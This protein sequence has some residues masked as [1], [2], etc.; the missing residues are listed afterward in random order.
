MFGKIGEMIIV[1]NYL[2]KQG[3][4]KRHFK[5]GIPSPNYFEFHKWLWNGK[6]PL[7]ELVEAEIEYS[8]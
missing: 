4:I 6:R 7:Q 8:S 1:G 2:P 5:F 3:E